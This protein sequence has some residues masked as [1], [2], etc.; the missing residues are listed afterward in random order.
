LPHAMPRNV[1][2]AQLVHGDDAV[3]ARHSSGDRSSN[4]Q[5]SST[6]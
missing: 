2:E 5:I 4:P 3:T 1:E 6:Y